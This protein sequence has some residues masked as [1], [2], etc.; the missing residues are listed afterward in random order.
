MSTCVFTVSTCFSLQRV[1]AVWPEA[2]GQCV[3]DIVDSVLVSLA[4]CY[5]TAASARLTTTVLTRPADV[6]VSIYNYMYIY[7]SSVVRCYHGGQFNSITLRC[8]RLNTMEVYFCFL[9]IS[10]NSHCVSCS[11]RTNLPVSLL[12][13]LPVSLMCPLVSPCSVSVQCG[14]K[15]RVSVCWT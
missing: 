10:K 8:W 3:L 9:E 11:V 15:Q 7:I 5:W 6:V 1:S 4:W 2:T 14:R 12:V 13:C